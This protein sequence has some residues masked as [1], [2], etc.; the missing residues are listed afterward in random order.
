MLCQSLDRAVSKV[1]SNSHKEEQERDRDTLGGRKQRSARTRR[2]NSQF[3]GAKNRFS[4][5]QVEKKKPKRGEKESRFVTTGS[6]RGEFEKM[7]R[8][9]GMP[10]RVKRALKGT[11]YHFC[12]HFR[13][14]GKTSTQGRGK[15]RQKFSLEACFYEGSVTKRQN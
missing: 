11:K 7:Q 4:H 14:G 6:G 8:R 3:F 10:T 9:R 12:R 1:F 2:D 15:N 13:A 5:K